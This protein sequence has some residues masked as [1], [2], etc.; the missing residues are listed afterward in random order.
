MNNQVKSISV[1]IP[2]Y[3]RGAILLDTIRMLLA[4]VDR[5]EQILIVDQT[6]YASGDEV[7]LSLQSLHTNKEIVWIRLAQPSI[8][9]AMNRGLI[10]ASSEYVLFLDDDIEIRSGFIAKHRQALRNADFCGHV[11]Q[12]IQP[13]QSV[14]TL[15][16]YSPDTGINR[17]IAF[18]F[19]SDKEQ[20]I[21]NCMAGNLC[22]ARDQAIDVGGFDERFSQVAYRFETEFCRRLMHASGHAFKFVPTPSIN[23]LKL[24][25]GGTRSSARDHLTSFSSAHSVGDYY[26][27]MQHFRL[28]GDLLQVCTYISKRLLQSCLSKFYLSHPWWIPVR[29]FAEC[30]GLIRAIVKTIKGPSYIG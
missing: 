20:L 3:N 19:N 18:P 1:V 6:D 15:K 11:G 12:I 22:V 24:S 23:H 2:T 16:N 26:F 7:A 21:H 28:H 13:W 29:L 17:D 10:D 14:V 4:Q 5:A 25:T 9:A 30:K 8:P 27:A